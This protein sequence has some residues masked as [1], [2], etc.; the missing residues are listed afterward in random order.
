VQKFSGLSLD[1]VEEKDPVHIK[2]IIGSCHL[3][4]GSR[5]HALV[6]ALSQGVPAVATS[7]SH[8]YERLYEEY[9]CQEL[10]ISNLDFE[11]QAREVMQNL[12]DREKYDGIVLTLNE[13]G[14][15]QLQRTEQMW[16]NVIKAM[17][18]DNGITK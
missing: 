6:S 5:F 11:E 15:R 7:W 14:R 12:T 3:V 2:G 10:L 18:P 8:K 4:V 17:D 1:I 13:S 16:Q 9:E